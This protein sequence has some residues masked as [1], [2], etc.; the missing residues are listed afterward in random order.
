ML[1]VA[2][3]NL[4]GFCSREVILK[5]ILRTFFGCLSSAMSYLHSIKIRHR[6][7]KPEN[8]LVKGKHVYLADFGISLDWE[9]LTRGTTVA[10]SG[11]TLAYCA[12]EVA[13]HQKRNSSSDIWSLGCVFLEICT[14]LKDRNLDQMRQF[15][16][17]RTDTW[18]YY[19]NG[20]SIKE[21]MGTLKACGHESD[22]DPLE[23]VE[24]MLQID[25]TKR[26]P[27][28]ELHQ[29]SSGIRSG[30]GTGASPFCASCCVLEE[31]VSSEAGAESDDELW[32]D[33][34]AT[35]PQ[36]TD[37]I[38]NIQRLSTQVAAP[39]HSLATKS[40]AEN[41][42]KAVDEQSGQIAA[43]KNFA[44]PGSL[45]KSSDQPRPVTTVDQVSAGE[46]LAATV[47]PKVF[48]KSLPKLSAQDWESPARMMLV[49][50][51]DT[52]FMNSLLECRPDLHEDLLHSRT[53]S[54][55]ELIE[56]LIREGL[57]VNDGKYRDAELGG[58]A[59]RVLSWS[60][61]R[62]FQSLFR[63]LIRKI[64]FGGE[65]GKKAKIFTFTGKSGLIWAI[66]DLVELDLSKPIEWKESL[67]HSATSQGN[68]VTLKH[69][70]SSNVFTTTDRGPNGFTILHGAVLYGYKDIVEW[71]LEGGKTFLE[72]L[73]HGLTPLHFACKG[74]NEE[75]VRLLI[76]HGANTSARVELE[77]DDTAPVL[78]T[79][80][81]MACLFNHA[82]VLK[83]LLESHKD[84]LVRR[85]MD[86]LLLTICRKN[87]V[88]VAKVL[89]SEGAD[90]NTNMIIKRMTCLHIAAEEGF[91]DLARL[92]LA[93][94]ADLN[95]RCGST[96]SFFARKTPMDLAKKG[97][98]QDI[99]RMLTMAKL[100][101]L[102][103]SEG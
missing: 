35:S 25:S 89:L 43:T 69:I 17:E 81:A 2:E 78:S 48:P 9:N 85:D 54:L 95:A 84:F 61:E 37:N 65:G 33:E 31:E 16:K 67:T 40:P 68:L 60:D 32:A 79:P 82:S 30:S 38:V 52:Q 88:E 86:Q 56:C 39:E 14:V 91:G 46:H 18:A 53:A 73:W 75:I 77:G 58:P 41:Q 5:P 45:E 51:G 80:M 21:W 4:R 63:L 24:S 66:D 34:Q 28:S 99:I 57:D 11:K 22:N 20:P 93:N 49:I 83:V 6:D 98:H 13:N 23:W 102:L 74:G 15:F 87:Q 76:N 72:T 44:K 64:D 101:R 42:E 12:P 97:G 8:I 26:P 62:D 10:D 7:I 27:A 3:C 71:A 94:G 100:D 19:K 90:V 70:Q 103:E 36:L 1:P 55:I 47:E 92:L 50:S 59:S 29:Y 96:Y